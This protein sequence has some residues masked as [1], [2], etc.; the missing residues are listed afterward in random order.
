[1]PHPTD[2]ETERLTNSITELFFKRELL[3][4]ES[5]YELLQQI[6]V[7]LLDELNTF[8]LNYCLAFGLRRGQREGLESKVFSPDQKQ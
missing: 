4:K 5:V 6:T 2:L 3:Y 8:S 7:E 1:M